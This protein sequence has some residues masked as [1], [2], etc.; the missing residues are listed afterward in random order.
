MLFKINNLNRAGVICQE[1]INSLKNL[2]IHTTE[3]LVADGLDSAYLQWCQNHDRFQDKLKVLNASP[4]IHSLLV[5]QEQISILEAMNT[6]WIFTYQKTT[7][8]KKHL[9][10]MMKQEK[11]SRDG[12]IYQYFDSKDHDLLVV[13]N[14]IIT[15]KDFLESEFEVR[16]SKLISILDAKKSER[17]KILYYQFTLLVLAIV[18][19][20]STIL[21]TFL[22][23]L[24]VS[25]GDLHR[26]ME[27]IGRGDFSEKLPITGNDELSRIAEAINSTTDKLSDMHWELEDRI[28]ELFYAKIEADKANQAKS[29]FLAN[30]SHEIRTPLNAVTGFSEL[31][32]GLIKDEQQKSY[33]SAI[34]QAGKSLL[35]LINDILDMS[36]IESGKLEI[37]YTFIDLRTLLAEVRQIFEAEVAKRD[38]VFKADISNDLPAT[39]CLD[40]IRLRQV[41]FNIVGN[42]VKFTQSGYVRMSADV[43]GQKENMIDLKLTIED[44]GIGIHENEMASIFDAFRQQTG[45]DHSRFGGTGLGLAIS[46]RLVEMMNGRIFVQSAMGLG[47]V[48]SIVLKDIEYENTIEKGAVEEDKGPDLLSR[49]PL[50]GLSDELAIKLPEIQKILCSDYLILWKEIKDRLPVDDVKS[51]G[52]ELKNLGSRYNFI[53]L[54]AYG[55]ELISY[56]DSFNINGMR[57]FIDAFPKIVEQL[58]KEMK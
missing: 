22:L 19:I 33:L 23:R 32:S 51:F 21:I 56:V 6:F 36:K 55:N 17:L 57:S 40:E 30:M 37:N 42:A 11:R 35:M 58:T 24:K 7:R 31:L 25:L 14:D 8:V 48:F 39:L 44:T 9:S 50:D 34:K 46:K 26:S 45:Q 47:S 20:V 54:E 27:K 53:Y 4:I 41:M 29:A 16:L 13:R 12:L 15:A 38:I 18:L 52:L 1:T 2:Q 5:T 43:V 28:E 10:E 3:L 49:N